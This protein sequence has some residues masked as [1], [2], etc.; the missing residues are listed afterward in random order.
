MSGSRGP[1]PV[2]DGGMYRIGWM[3][4]QCWSLVRTCEARV[5]VA[6]SLIAYGLEG[7]SDPGG[8]ELSGRQCF[9]L[10]RMS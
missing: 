8:T 6:L 1:P 5:Q 4:L 3:L 7:V 2:L 10:H 9:V